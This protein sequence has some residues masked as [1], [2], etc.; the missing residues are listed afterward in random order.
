M[1][2][3]WTRP[4]VLKATHPIRT[5]MQLPYIDIYELRSLLILTLLS[6]TQFT[7]I[8][9]EYTL[10]QWVL[11]KRILALWTADCTCNLFGRENSSGQDT[12]DLQILLA[13]K[14]PMVTTEIC[15]YTFLAHLISIRCAIAIES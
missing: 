2:A 6:S 12:T 14:L 9:V 13:I 7:H 5:K 8:Y 4:I 1:D 11:Q 3:A 10:C 15:Y